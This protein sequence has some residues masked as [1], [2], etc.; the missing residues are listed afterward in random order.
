MSRIYEALQKA[1]SERQQERQEREPI[2]RNVRSLHRHC[3]SR[4]HW[5]SMTLLLYGTDRLRRFDAPTQQS[6]RI[7]PELI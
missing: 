7:G 3:A 4:R 5:P 1:E 2:R 6:R